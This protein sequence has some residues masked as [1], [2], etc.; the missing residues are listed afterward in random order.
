MPA[1]LIVCPFTE[2]LV[3]TRVDAN[4][5]GELEEDNVLVRCPECGQDHTWTPREAVVSVAE[6]WGGV[7]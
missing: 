2:D 7:G 1:V 4:D 5:L 3:S 6:H